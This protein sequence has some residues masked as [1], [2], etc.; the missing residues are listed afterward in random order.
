[1][2]GA[3]QETP[4]ALGQAD[5]GTVVGG[6]AWSVLTAVMP[7]LQTLAVS[8]VAARFLGTV[9][10]GQQSLIA[11]VSV[12]CSYV[13][14]ARM[15]AALRRFG[16]QMLGAG[17][18]GMLRTLYVRTFRVQIAVGFA[19]LLGFA[20]LA[21]AGAAP[22]PAW[23]IAGFATFGAVMQAAPSNLLIAAQRWRDT[24]LP[25]TILAFAATI[26]MVIVLVLGGGV[27]GYFAVDAAMV[28]ANLFWTWRLARR[29]LVLLP[30]AEPIE[31]KLSGEFRTFIRA[32]TFFAL[33][34]FVVLNRSEILFLNHFSTSAQ[35]GFF[36]IAFAASE[37]V[38]RFPGILTNVALPTVA[39]LHGAGEHEKI[40]RGFWRAVRFLLAVCP[41]LVVVAAAL[42]ADLIGIVYGS[43]YVPAEPVVVILL[44]PY[45]V[46]PMSGLSDALLWTLGKIRFLV[47][48]GVAA[49]VVDVIAALV[50]IP[51]FDAIGAAIASDLG[52]LTAGLPALWLSAKL[53]GPI[54]L[55]GQVLLN[56][57]IVTVG[58]AAASI[59]PVVLIGGVPGLLVGALLVAAVGWVLATRLGILDA[60]DAEWLVGAIGGRFGGRLGTLLT[61]FSRPRPHDSPAI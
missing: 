41:P 46:L 28:G 52:A 36:S 45:L 3:P 13:L 42:G 49:A 34:E 25:G 47:L 19:L 14:A 17:Q 33:I 57:L 21:A 35:V 16:A 48:W 29:V 39:N 10:F 26:A 2:P 5:A 58:C 7:P 22:P 27:A 6:T 51:R 20:A 59:L 18:L 12:S 8:I 37:A 30:P 32:S 23:V 11:F 38:A 61:A 9:G 50:L 43:K 1:M 44:I 31:I 53:M 4:G 40:R 55:H 54:N 24:V 60:A 15:P 56:N